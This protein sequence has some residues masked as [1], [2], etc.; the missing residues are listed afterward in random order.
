MLTKDNDMCEH[1]CGPL[2][3]NNSLILTLENCAES[4]PVF[5]VNCTPYE[6]GETDL[7][8]FIWGFMRTDSILRSVSSGALRNCCFWTLTQQKL[9]LQY[10]L[11]YQNIHLSLFGL[12]W[13][14]CM[15]LFSNLSLNIFLGP[16]N[17]IK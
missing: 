14:T 8:E 17:A 5:I 2:I 16:L 3:S 11:I 9:T 7:T 6:N 10:L 1:W 13:N 12:A 4:A 15:H